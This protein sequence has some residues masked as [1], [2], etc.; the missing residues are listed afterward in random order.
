MIQRRAFL[1]SLAAGAMIAIAAPARAASGWDLLAEA[2]FRAPTTARARELLSQARIEAEAA[3]RRDPADREAGLRQAVAAAWGVMLA[4]GAGRAR[5]ARRLIER[6]IAA[7]PGNADAHLALGAWHIEA[8]RRVGML[9]GLI[10]ASRRDGNAA[11][12]RA[13][14]LGGDRALPAGYAALLRAASGEGR[15]AAERAAVLTL[16]RRAARGTT[17]TGLDAMMRANAERFAA[18]LADPRADAA[19]TAA[20]LLPFGRLESKDR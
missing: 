18:A 13:V 12:D 3:L 16:A 6:E 8:V 20:P 11:L 17:P 19:R 10:G 9:A 2:A 7:R 14:T 1:C 4:G 5:E 15:S